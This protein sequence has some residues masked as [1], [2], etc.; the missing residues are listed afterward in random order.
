MW[1]TVLVLAISMNFEPSRPVW[2][3]LML[4]RPRPILQLSAL[5][6]GSFLSGLGIGLLVLLVFHRT[7][8]GN[9][10]ASAA[11]M[12]ILVGVTSLLIAA[13]LASKISL[14]R[15]RPEVVGTSARPHAERTPI[16]KMADRARTILKK[17]NS[18]WLSAVIGLG[19]G[20]PSLE[21]L[22]ALIIIASSEAGNLVEITALVVFL[23]VGN[24]LITVPLITYLFAPQTTARWI[25]RFQDW[26]R[27]RGRREFA[28]IL[29]VMGLIQIVI[30]LIRL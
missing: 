5:F 26:L 12:Q 21:F 13:V 3:P 9:N 27:T 17:G 14:R 15:R 1:F 29:A 18:P 30:G 25:D 24:G 10:M 4:A 20:A 19:I 23:L 16:D 2:V 7:P 8:F 6:W 28:V 11:V 22:A